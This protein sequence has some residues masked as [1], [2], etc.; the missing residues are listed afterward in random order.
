MTSGPANIRISVEQ[1]W[2]SINTALN[3]ILSSLAVNKNDVRLYAG[4]GLAGCE[5]N[6][7]HDA[8]INHSHIFHTLLVTYDSHIACLGAHRGEDGAIIIAGTGAAGYQI[9]NGKTT[10]VG[11]WGFP[12]DDEGGGAFLG[13]AAMKIVLQW[14]DGRLPSSTLAQAVFD[15]FRRDQSDLVAWANRATSSMFAE[16]APLVIEQSQKGDP[17]A[18]DILKQAAQ[19]IDRIAD[20]LYAAQDTA[21]DALPCALIGSIAPFLKPLLKPKTHSRLTEALLSPDAGAI[22]LIRRHLA[23]LLILKG[24]NKT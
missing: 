8:F 23:Q 16:L 21:N 22:F 7:A 20:T 12:H 3:N 11:G 13:L 9:Q 5:I 6:E 15:Y 18:S 4:M 2:Q 1:A 17:V 10:K 14:L 19:A 24:R